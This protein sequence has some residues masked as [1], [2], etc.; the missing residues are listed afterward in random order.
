VREIG[1]LGQK[2]EALET[3]FRLHPGVF[4]ALKRDEL[5]TLYNLLGNEAMSMQ[6]SDIILA[7]RVNDERTM[8]RL[9]QNTEEVPA[10]KRSTELLGLAARFPRF[11]Y[12]Q[13]ALRL[14]AADLLASNGQRKLAETSYRLVFDGP[15]KYAQLARDKYSALV[16]KGGRGAT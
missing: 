2:I 3:W 15:G 7:N 8:Q 10:A 9:L 11:R 16:R 4:N 13:A 14:Q 5:R 12:V 6:Q 1:I